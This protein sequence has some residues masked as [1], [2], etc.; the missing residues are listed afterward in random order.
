[1]KLSRHI[2]VSLVVSSIIYFIFH[3]PAAFFSSLAGGVLIDIDHLADY[4]FQNGIDLRP[5][6]F[7][8]WCYCDKWQRLV[9]IMHSVELL[10]ILWLVIWVFNLGLVWMA[11]AVGMSQHLVLDI[12]S[13]KRMKVISYFFIFRCFRGFRK[14][15]ILRDR[16]G[17]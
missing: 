17:I 2:A 16:G 4:F 12:L 5:G 8:E 15:H 9:L 10:F 1:M 11:F 14:E 13:N 7:F 3:S 6:R